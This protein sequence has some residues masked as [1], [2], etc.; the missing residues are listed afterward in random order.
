MENR[1]KE[2]KKITNNPFLNYYEMKV[3]NKS[4]KEHPYYMATRMH[5]DRLK[6]MTDEYP[7]DGVLIYGIHQGEDGIDRVVLIRQLRYP[8]N[9][10]VYELP[11]GLID[12]GETASQAA[13]R[14]YR[15][16][17][18]LT[19]R[20]LELEEAVTKP[21]YSSV[22]MTDESVATAYGYA[23]GTVN[24][25]G[26]EENEDLTVILADREEAVRILK[27][28]QLCSKCAYLLLHFIQSENGNPFRFLE[29]FRK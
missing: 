17:T 20:P 21:F 23:T 28:E 27:E 4:G 10:Y 3:V 16:E 2:V 15:E 25:D 9:T 6:C 7:A 19:F 29:P 11:A 8:V 22:G 5:E 26:L 14:E 18:G 12:A 24:A 13:I 1:V